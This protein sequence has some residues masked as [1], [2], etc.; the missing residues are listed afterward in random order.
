MM[1]NTTGDLMLTSPDGYASSSLTTNS[2]SALLYP[3]NSCALTPSPSN[4]TEP[5]YIPPEFDT[6]A[7]PLSFTTINV[8]PS[9][10]PVDITNILI[11]V[12]PEKT[13][14]PAPSVS[15][16]SSN[17]PSMIN[18]PQEPSQNVYYYN[19]M[20]ESPDTVKRV[21]KEDTNIFSYQSSLAWT[22]HMSV[23]ILL[24]MCIICFIIIAKS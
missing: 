13:E 19:Y 11:Q 9:N 14:T 22:M 21:A 6:G 17:V 24:L 2:A 16:V 23:F 20:M 12:P 1:Y 4:I 15:H 3:T 18:M 10:M 5:D 8:S 7:D